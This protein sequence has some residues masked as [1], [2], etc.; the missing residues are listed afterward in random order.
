[1]PK[2]IVLSDHEVINKIHAAIKQCTEML[3]GGQTDK[4]S[5][6]PGTIKSL[7]D[8]I[9]DCHADLE[10]KWFSAVVKVGENG[11]QTTLTDIETRR[12][13]K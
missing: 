3:E 2:I 6:L 1:V 11:K 13:S 12:V 7:R 5:F 9:C 8:E 10:G 4:R